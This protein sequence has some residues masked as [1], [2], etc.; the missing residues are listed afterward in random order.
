M[1]VNKTGCVRGITPELSCALAFSQ[2]PTKLSHSR[3]FRNPGAISPGVSWSD[4]SYLSLIPLL[5]RYLPDFI[6]VWRPEEHCY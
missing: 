4:M 1:G 6:S 3:S 2:I 5:D